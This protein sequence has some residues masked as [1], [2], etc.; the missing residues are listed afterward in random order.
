MY[1]SDSELKYSTGMISPQI[2]PLHFQFFQAMDGFLLL[3]ADL[4]A[5]FLHKIIL[6]PFSKTL[7]GSRCGHSFPETHAVKRLAPAQPGS[8]TSG[9]QF[10]ETCPL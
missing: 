6:S 10:Q 4:Q 3:R 1:T 5:V 8:G 9:G 7:P 2:R